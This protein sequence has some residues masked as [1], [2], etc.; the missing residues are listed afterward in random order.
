MSYFGAKLNEYL[1]AN[2][3]KQTQLASMTGISQGQISII[4]NGEQR[5]VSPETMELICNAFPIS[6]KEKA[7]LI[8]AHLLD[9]CHGPGSELIEIKIAGKPPAFYD[10]PEP[11]APGIEKALDII[12]KNTHNKE[13]RDILI[14]LAKLCCDE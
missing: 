1:E 5:W 7:E 2:G 11:L 8:R 10:K 13:L 3:M 9:E 12:R 14:S 6:T 4:V